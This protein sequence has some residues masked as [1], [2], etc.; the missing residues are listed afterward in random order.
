MLLHEFMG[1][2]PIYS[3]YILIIFLGEKFIAY[4]FTIEQVCK[5]SLCEHGTS[6]KAISLFPLKVC[7][8]LV[9][10]YISTVGA[11]NLFA[12]IV[13]FVSCRWNPL[14][15]MLARGKWYYIMSEKWQFNYLF[16]RSFTTE[17]PILHILLIRLS[18]QIG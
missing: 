17:I 11:V 15:T 13:W 9:G 10:F 3:Q 16:R 7:E 5:F 1:W 6:R 18:T 12:G 8:M 14:W 2:M 4:S